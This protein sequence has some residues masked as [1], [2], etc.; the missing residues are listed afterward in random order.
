MP[1]LTRGDRVM[2][3]SERSHARTTV[4]RMLVSDAPTWAERPAPAP[5]RSDATRSAG[6]SDATRSHSES[7]RIESR[8]NPRKSSPSG[9]L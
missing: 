3:T 7:A 8:R 5:G 1:V 4:V 9:L 6:R 2:W